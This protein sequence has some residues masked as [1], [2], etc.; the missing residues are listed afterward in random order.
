[1]ASAPGNVFFSGEHAVVYGRPAIVA[2]IEK[3]TYVEICPRDDDRVIVN[4]REFGI[5][6][7]RVNGENKSGP[8]E[9]E[10]ILDF[11]DSLV[12]KSTREKGFEVKIW[13]EIPAESGMSSSTAVLSALLDALNDFL[14]LGISRDN[15]FQVIFPFQE[16]IHG[17]K[18]SGSEI[19]SSVFGGFHWLDRSNGVVEKIA[20]FEIP[21][22]IGDTLVRSPTKLTV[23]YHVPSLIDRYPEM[24]ED[25]W[26]QI[27][28][29]TRK[30]RKA[31]ESR[32]LAKIGDLMNQNQE[33][34]SSLGLSHPK[35][36]DLISEAL[37]AGAVGAKLSGSGWGGIMFAVCYP[38]DQKKVADAMKK[39]RAR[40]LV[41]SL[42]G[43]GLTE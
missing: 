4:S 33:V 3:R 29:I 31:L 35:L 17:G 14:G 39:T 12:T 9:L 40:I 37:K 32:D 7:M 25:A 18:A 22:V 5:A 27:A 41:T 36:D 30:M 15:Y 42:G 26:N 16:R 21:V 8:K 24:V 2:S 6:D 38:E 19:Y 43:P 11:I 23:G 34:L 28:E 20:E 13:S 10:V 1:M